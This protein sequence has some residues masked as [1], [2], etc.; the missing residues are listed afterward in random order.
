MLYTKLKAESLAPHAGYLRRLFGKGEDTLQ[1]SLSVGVC[2]KW[3]TTGG[4]LTAEENLLYFYILD[5][6]YYKKSTQSY[7]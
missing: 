7:L 1:G 6:F 3:T 4:T 5:N 2:H